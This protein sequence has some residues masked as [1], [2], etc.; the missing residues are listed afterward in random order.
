MQITI[1]RN[2]GFTLI[3]A[4]I[5]IA[6]VGA[7]AGIGI[8]TYQSFTVKAKKAE[9]KANL[10]GLVT[11]EQ[12][13]FT[14]YVAYT[15]RFDA[16]GYRPDGPLNFVIGFNTD[17]GPPSTFTFPNLSTCIITR[18]SGG[19]LPACSYPVT[20]TNNSSALKAGSFPSVAVVAGR[21]FRA[22]ALGQI[23]GAGID[24]W[25]IDQSGTLTESGY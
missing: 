17:F 19:A 14:Q 21:N 3:E 6:I 22:A 4:M 7:L 13:F 25:S 11:A 12:S 8:P 15:T 9:A 24:S 1:L 18:D 16:I 2:K 10:A 5:T 23:S 20:W